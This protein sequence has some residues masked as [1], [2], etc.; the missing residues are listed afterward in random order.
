M[1]TQEMQKMK[2]TILVMAWENKRDLVLDIGTNN[3][4]V[5]VHGKSREEIIQIW[6]DEVI[7]AKE[8]LGRK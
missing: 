7:Q 6:E 3:P 5:N 8:R 2:D 1:V 4:H